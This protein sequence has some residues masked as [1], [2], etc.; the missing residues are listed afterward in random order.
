MSRNAKRNSK[1]NTNNQN[2]SDAID[3][4]SKNLS[5][6]GVSDDKIVFAVGKAGLSGDKSARQLDNMVKNYVNGKSKSVPLYPGH[7]VD[8]PELP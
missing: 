1:S 8:C 3:S 5:Q 6:L 4:L 7:K 2:D